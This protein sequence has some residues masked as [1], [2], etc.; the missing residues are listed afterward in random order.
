MSKN[1]ILLSVTMFGARDDLTQ[2]DLAE[3]VESNL[4]KYVSWAMGKGIPPD[5]RSARVVLAGAPVPM[6]QDPNDLPD[7]PFVKESLARRITRATDRNITYTELAQMAGRKSPSVRPGHLS[8]IHRGA[9]RRV[10]FD[11]IRA[12]EWAL[13]TFEK[14]LDTPA[15]APQE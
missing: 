11:Q 13:D 4:L 5:W 9:P 6:D 2:E 3:R 14:A 7:D 12:I 15:P 8:A 10:S 1:S